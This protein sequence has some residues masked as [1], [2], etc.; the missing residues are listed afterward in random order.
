MLAQYRLNLSPL[1]PT[2]ASPNAS[3]L[4]VRAEENYGFIPNM[5]AYMAN[6]PGLF[7]TYV[8]GHDQFRR[9][10]GFTPAEQEVVFLTI[11]AENGCEYCVSAHSM[12]ADVISKLPANQT[13]AIRNGATLP[14]AKLN[15]LSVFTKNMVIKRGLPS[16][17]DVEQFLAAGF[18]EYQIL[19]VILAIAVK[20]ISNYTNHI[21]HTP[22][23]LAFAPHAWQDKSAAQ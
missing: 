4:L 14:D 7:A 3:A 1:N 6:S 2:T 12:I 10:S 13:Q 18:T 20:T 5:F 19:E 8:Q 22:L 16:K 11:S 15:A 23:D 21:V 9:N 17:G